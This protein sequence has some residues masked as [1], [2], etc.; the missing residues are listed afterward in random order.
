MK[1]KYVLA[2]VRIR[3]KIAKNILIIVINL[4]LMI[5]IIIGFVSQLITKNIVEFTLIIFPI[6]LVLAF[7]LYFV[8]N[9]MFPKSRKLNCNFQ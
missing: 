2:D 4:V 3:Y 7:F 1:K 6:E 8:Y 5:L 9:K